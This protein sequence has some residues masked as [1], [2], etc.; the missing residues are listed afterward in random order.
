[1]SCAQRALN[2]PKFAQPNRLRRQSERLWAAANGGVAGGG[3]FKGRLATLPGHRPFSPFFFLFAPFSRGPEEHLGNTECAREG[4]FTQMSS[5]LRGG[6]ERVLHFM[7]REIKGRQKIRM[8]AVKWVVAKL[9]GD[10]S[11]TFCRKMSGR[12]VTGR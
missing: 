10:T 7:G 6:C 8:Q 3:V 11:A 9:H 2:T 5:E 12:E 4:P 1:M